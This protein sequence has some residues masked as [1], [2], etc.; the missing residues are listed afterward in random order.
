M[1]KNSFH[2]FLKRYISSKFYGAVNGGYDCG[3][4]SYPTGFLFR[5]K[6]IRMELPLSMYKTNLLVLGCHKSYRRRLTQQYAQQLVRNGV[7]VLFITDN[8]SPH[9]YRAELEIDSF[10]KHIGLQTLDQNLVHIEEL[11][12]GFDRTPFDEGKLLSILHFDSECKNRNEGP[13][14][15]YNQ[16]LMSLLQGLARSDIAKYDPEKEKP[17][18]VVFI[19]EDI[20]KD[21]F[22]AQLFANTLSDIRRQYINYVICGYS[23]GTRYKHVANDFGHYVFFRARDPSHDFK[24]LPL[25]KRYNYCKGAEPTPSHRDFM[26]L[27]RKDFYY[28]MGNVAGWSNKITF[29]GGGC[30]CCVEP[31]DDYYGYVKPQ[32]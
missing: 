27:G 5:T 7:R 18:F 8:L 24:D 9:Q 25:I 30:D 6:K 14:Q 12:G 15:E 29:D 3:E 23:V 10:K 28:T 22:D 1:H 11:S 2:R 13:R 4:F 20:Y 16:K 31:V 17:D 26:S 21:D 32:E 19:D